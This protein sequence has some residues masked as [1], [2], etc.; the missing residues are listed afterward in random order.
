MRIRMDDG[1]E[2]EVGP[3]DFLSVAPGHDAWVVG[4]ERCIMVDFGASVDVYAKPSVGESRQPNA[5]V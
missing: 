1:S 2:D 4:N 5:R 3:G